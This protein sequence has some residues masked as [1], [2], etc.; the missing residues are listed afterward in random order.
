LF[1]KGRKGSCEHFKAEDKILLSLD[2]N[3][4]IRV[5]A[6]ISSSLLDEGLAFIQQF[7]TERLKETAREGA[8]PSASLSE[9]IIDLEVLGAK[10]HGSN[11]IEEISWKGRKTYPIK[12]A[13]SLVILGPLYMPDLPAS[14]CPQCL[15]RRWFNN[16]RHE[17]QRSIMRAQQVIATGHNPRIVPFT[18]EALWQVFC[19]SLEQADAAARNGVFPFY[20][21]NLETLQISPYRLLQDASCPGCRTPQPDSSE[22]ASLELTSRPK[23]QFSRYRLVNATDYD[24]PRTGLINPI[25]GVMGQ[26]SIAETVH[27][28][29]SPVFGQFETRSKHGLYTIMWSG[30]GDSYHQSLYLGLLEAI[31]R[32]SGLIPRG[33]V[34]SVYD[35]YNNLAEQAL[36]PR[37]CGLYR[38][39]FYQMNPDYLPFSPERPLSWVWGYSFQQAR[40]IL[41]PEQ[42]V[43]YMNYRH[44][45]TNFVHDCS[46]GCATGSCLEEA[47]LYGLM[48]LIERDAF[49]MTWYARLAPPK[50]NPRSSRCLETLFA[51]EGIERLGYDLY[52]FDTRFDVRIPSIL[53]LA[54][55]KEPG[56]ANIVVSAGAGLNPEDAIRSAL[57]ELTCYIPSGFAAL[58]EGRDLSRL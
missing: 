31:E 19:T 34:P 43:Y 46:S 30:H 22:A 58:A 13:R 10:D 40:P 41:V 6:T 48:E 39:E 50:I 52:L 27:T 28:L 33:K 36:D 12:L 42:L 18:L 4:G 23:R 8:F 56:L 44:V 37:T 45:K 21:L 25:S 54:K 38:P 16:R 14:P 57:C 51:L 53:A 29:S 47:I 35:S 20:V 5:Q 3:M 9:L 7:L 24:L 15:S 1:F 55:R 2:Q 26:R 17:E 49:L 11:Q 32:Y